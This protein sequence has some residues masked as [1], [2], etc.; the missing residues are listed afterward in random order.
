LIPSRRKICTKVFRTDVVPAPDEPVIEMMG[1][2]RDMNP[3][4][5]FMHML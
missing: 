5:R 2:R 4:P 3:Q 1:W